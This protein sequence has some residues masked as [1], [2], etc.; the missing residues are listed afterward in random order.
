MAPAWS[1]VAWA[2]W[3]SDNVYIYIWQQR[4]LKLR[5]MWSLLVWVGKGVRL[6]SESLLHAVL[7]CEGFAHQGSTIT[8]AL[9]GMGGGGVIFR[10]QQLQQSDDGRTGLEQMIH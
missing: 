8:H 5:S 4:L 3:L 1:L 9:A 6:G 2:V 7:P 10:R